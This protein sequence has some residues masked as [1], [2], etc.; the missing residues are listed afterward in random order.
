MRIPW[1]LNENVA[2]LAVASIAIDLYLK[3]SSRISETDKNIFLKVQDRIRAIETVLR[4]WLK[5]GLD[6][7]LNRQREK[8]KK[9][10]VLL[11]LKKSCWN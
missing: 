9:S 6:T 5:L 7:E 1:N 8:K 3:S 11:T 4:G 10:L 2:N